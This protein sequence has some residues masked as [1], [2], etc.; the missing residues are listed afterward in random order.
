[1]ARYRSGQVGDVVDQ[2]SK[3]DAGKLTELRCNTRGLGFVCKAAETVIKPARKLCKFGKCY[4]YYDKPDTWANAQ[5]QCKKLDGTLLKLESEAEESYI[6]QKLLKKSSDED[7]INLWLGCNDQANEGTFTWTDGTPC[8]PDQPDIYVNWA[9]G[10]PDNI[11]GRGRI[12]GDCAEIAWIFRWNRNGPQPVDGQWNDKDCGAMNPYVCTVTP[13]PPPPGGGGKQPLTFT[14][15]SGS[16]VYQFLQDGLKSWDNALYK[17]QVQGGSLVWFEEER[18]ERF[19]EKVVMDESHREVWIG[20]SDTKTEG[21]WVQTGP[22]QASCGPSSGY[23]NWGNDMPKQD[24]RSNCVFKVWDQ[25]FGIRNYAGK[26]RDAPCQLPEVA[27]ICK[28]PVAAD[29][30]AGKLRKRG[31][32]NYRMGPKPA[33][34]RW[35]AQRSCENQGGSLLWLEDKDEETWVENTVLG[36]AKRSIWLA[37]NDMGKERESTFTQMTGPDSSQPCGPDANYQNWHEGEP[38]QWRGRQQ[39]SVRR[40]VRMTLPLTLTPNLTPTHPTNT[41]HSLTL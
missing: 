15:K 3:P 39:G 7:S 18:E 12:E 29:K 13:P 10:Q 33:P 40:C 27:A 8:G 22:S 6:E 25:D 1:M 31:G 17:C 4:L 20:C 11:G 38:N 37:C 19:V 5:A 35:A 28:T 34:N 9:E 41:H 26:W 16:Y 2:I 24:K 23:S 32:F 36:G 30:D 21:T 14:T